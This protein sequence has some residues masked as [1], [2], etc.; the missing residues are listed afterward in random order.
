MVDIPVNFKPLR[1]MKG[2]GIKNEDISEDFRSVNMTALVDSDGFLSKLI[3]KN[4]HKVN[5]KEAHIVIGVE[6]INEVIYS[7][8][9]KMEDNKAIKPSNVL[10]LNMNLADAVT[11]NLLNVAKSVSVI[12]SFKKK[13]VD[14]KEVEVFVVNSKAIFATRYS[15]IEICNEVYY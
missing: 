15:D 5:L 9:K 4:E 13:K 8:L 7:T 10:A 3:F 1:Y 12:G 6:R 14:S 11:N 2:I